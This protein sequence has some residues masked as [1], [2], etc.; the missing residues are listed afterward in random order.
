M[1]VHKP[2]KKHILVNPIEKVFR[3]QSK[4]FS[5]KQETILSPILIN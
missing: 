1:K 4:P 3:Q 5:I 2:I